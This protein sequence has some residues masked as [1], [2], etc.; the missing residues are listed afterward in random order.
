MLR[1][2]AG[3]LLVTAAHRDLRDGAGT[4]VRQAI[5]ALDVDG[6]DLCS[7][8][9]EDLGNFFQRRAPVCLFSGLFRQEARKAE[10][11]RVSGYTK[12]TQASSK[13]IQTV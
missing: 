13:A 4:Y 6:A 12:K 9:V 2:L 1:D 7:V 3:F 5:D 8:A 11:Y 10:T